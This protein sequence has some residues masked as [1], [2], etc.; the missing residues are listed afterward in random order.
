MEPSDPYPAFTGKKQHVAM[1]MTYMSKTFFII[2]TET[3]LLSCR[4]AMQ[5]SGFNFVVAGALVLIS[6]YPFVLFFPFPRIS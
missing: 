1:V 4:F 5:F 2:L 6:I 3:T